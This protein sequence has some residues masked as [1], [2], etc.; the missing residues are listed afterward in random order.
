MKAFEISNLIKVGGAARARAYIKRL[1]LKERL[2]LLHDCMPYINDSERSL[3]FFRDNFA[4]EIGAMVSADYDYVKAEEIYN[5][6]KA[7]EK[8]R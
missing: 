2:P 7:S 1:A 6:A 4:Q 8:K 5:R 3:T